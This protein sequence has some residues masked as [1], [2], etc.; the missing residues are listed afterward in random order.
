MD[1]FLFDGNDN[2]EGKSIVDLLLEQNTTLIY[3]NPNWIIT[4]CEIIKYN[5][6]KGKKKKLI[7]IVTLKSLFTL[8]RRP[9]D[10][11][12]SDI[13]QRQFETIKFIKYKTK[14][15]E[16]MYLISSQIFEGTRFSL[17]N[18]N[19]IRTDTDFSTFESEC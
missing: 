5:E 1:E 8:Y 4:N 7:E 2:T 3:T 12:K 9:N 19:P 13:L 16:N 10:V 15:N 18:A 11:T 17:D 6:K 14:K